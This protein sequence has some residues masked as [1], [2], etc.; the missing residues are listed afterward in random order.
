MSQ[1]GAEI[2]INGAI[3]IPSLK[4]RAFEAAGKKSIIENVFL[5]DDGDSPEE[6]HRR[7]A[8]LKKHLIGMSYCVWGW[9]LEQQV[10]PP[11]GKRIAHPCRPLL[12]IPSPFQ[13]FQT[14]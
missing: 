14:L 5:V 4:A 11:I 10:K 13:N 9:M 6:A 12:E 2:E 8:V 7:L 1:W 3:F